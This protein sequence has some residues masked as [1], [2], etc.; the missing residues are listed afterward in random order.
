M[1]VRIADR[2]YAG[3][4]AVFIQDCVA[5]RIYDWRVGDTELR[6]GKI[7]GSGMGYITGNPA[8][9]ERPDKDSAVIEGVLTRHSRS[10]K[11]QE[12]KIEQ[13]TEHWY[14]PGLGLYLKFVF[15]HVGEGTTTSRIFNLNRAEPDPA[16][17]RVPDGFTSRSSDCPAPPGAAE[18]YSTIDGNWRLTGAWA[19][20]L[21]RGIDINLSIDGNTIYGEGQFPMSCITADKSSVMGQEVSI[22]GEIGSDGTFILSNPCRMPPGI[23]AR[24]VSI[25]GKLPTPDATQWSGS[26]SISA[27]TKTSNTPAECQGISADFVAKQFPVLN[28]MYEGTVRIDGSDEAYVTLELT[29]GKLTST[30]RPYPFDHI[31]PLEAKITVAG[32]SNVP[33]GTFDASAQP[34]ENNSVAGKTFQLQFLGGKDGASFE[35]T[36]GFDPSDES[37]LTL[38]L[39]YNSRDEREA[40]MLT[41]ASPVR[42]AGCTSERKDARQSLDCDDQIALPAKNCWPML[43]L[44]REGYR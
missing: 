5:H 43:R 15:Y 30:N 26:L 28:G 29:Q 34:Q 42:T 3:Y 12:G 21:G 1:V 11:E 38:N 16:L 23:P 13:R 27:F 7:G 32:S 18:S 33:S 6:C 40:K 22:E 17:F 39:F 2:R 4:T 19:E 10:V 14:A 35:A 20:K 31:I 24:V 41:V 9:P 8:A 44:V 36:G 37:R 25:R